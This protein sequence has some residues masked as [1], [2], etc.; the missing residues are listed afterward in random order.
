MSHHGNNL[1]RYGHHVTVHRRHLAACE[2]LYDRLSLV[3]A[4]TIDHF[5]VIDDIAERPLSRT[6]RKHFVLSVFTR[7]SVILVHLC[8]CG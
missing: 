3:V 2:H 7:M 8:V 4:I 5:L 1:S 6:Y